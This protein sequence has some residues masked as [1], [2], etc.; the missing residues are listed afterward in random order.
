MGES[1]NSTQASAT[2]SAGGGYSI[3]GATGT[4]T[5]RKPITVN[6]G[7]VTGA[8]TNFPM[9]VF[10][11]ADSQLSAGALANGNDIVFTDSNSV[12]LP[13]QI[14]SY[15]A[16]TLYAWVQVPSL[17]VG[18]QIYMYYGNASAPS[19]LQNAAGVWDSNYKGVWHLGSPT[20]LS[21]SDSTGVNNGVNNGA[22]AA[23]GKLFGG[24][25]FAG[26]QSIDMPDS[27]SLRIPGSWTLSAW[28]KLSSIPSTYIGV[29]VKGNGTNYGIGYDKNFVR[30]DGDGWFTWLN[31][32][33]TGNTDM[34]KFLQTPAT[35]T[36]YH[37]TG[38]WDDAG[39]QQ[40]LYLNGSQVET[41]SFGAH[42][43]M[44]DS[45]V[46]SIG[47]DPCCV[48]G[49]VSGMVDEVRVSATIRSTNWI[50]AEYSNQNAPASFYT[51]GGQQ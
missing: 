48:D 47:M 30:G 5:Y 33:V 39:Q 3:S 18:T 8:H 27:P 36:W 6:A 20:T 44:I 25:T 7:Q 13:Y 42:H 43:P 51:V 46:F 21:A 34:T 16:G 22:T 1:G 15:G 11:N 40:T 2:P 10:L 29:A 14:E 32:Y 24:A 19:N 28:V 49:Y 45:A 41:A 50:T 17:T 37:L 31:D 23:S 9:F 35:G 26:G 38:V 4:W 12:K